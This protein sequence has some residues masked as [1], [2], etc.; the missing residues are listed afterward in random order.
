MTNLDKYIDKLKKEINKHK[1]F[2]EDEIIRFIY[3]SIA[4][5][6]KFDVNWVY[7]N[8]FTRS[9]IY[10]KED[11]P[12]MINQSEK[13][14]KWIIICKGIAYLLSYVGKQ[15]G[16]NI[17]TIQEKPN[18]WNPY[19]H[20]YN[21]VKRKDG[22]EYKLDL[23]ADLP[24]IHNNRR[25]EFFGFK[26]YVGPRVFSR[27]Q[28]EEMDYKVGYISK[29]KPY[30]DEYYGLLKMYL[31]LQDSVLDRMSLI[32]ENPYPYIDANLEYEE[33][34]RY[35]IYT[36]Q[37]LLKNKENR[38]WKW[39]WLDCYYF[40]DKGVIP[41]EIIYIKDEEGYRFYEYNLENKNYNQ[42]T[43]EEMLSMVS[44][45][46]RLPDG[47]YTKDYSWIFDEKEDSVQGTIF[48]K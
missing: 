26:D 43:K 24:N 3:F 11:T 42:I 9:S 48:S 14:N 12:E 29:T 2:T 10:Y 41:K 1:D 46:L 15:I 4:K 19:P 44:S 30:S 35:I 23:Y 27:K 6:I 17:E 34:K 39:E 13:D 40:N 32:L 28:L 20:V 37:N 36:I 22:S 16:I 18:A 5:K 31:S 25:T 8:D 47:C 7:G 21:N 33:R 45:G 38:T